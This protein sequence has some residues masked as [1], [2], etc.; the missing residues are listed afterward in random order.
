[1]WPSAPILPL[2]PF[3]ASVLPLTTDL[4]LNLGR[5]S[6]SSG[7][8]QAYTYLLTYLCKMG[9]PTTSFWALHFPSFGEGRE[10]GVTVAF[11]RGAQLY[12]NGKSQGQPPNQGTAALEK[13]RLACRSWSWNGNTRLQAGYRHGSLPHFKGLDF[14]LHNAKTAASQPGFAN[15]RNSLSGMHKRKLGGERPQRRSTQLSHKT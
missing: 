6:G 2:T 9:T 8:Q 3:F 13:L 14:P 11:L 15:T 12:E 1:M 10:R 7:E 4:S 5:G